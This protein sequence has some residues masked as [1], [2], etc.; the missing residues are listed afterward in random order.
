MDF[1]GLIQTGRERLRQWSLRRSPNGELPADATEANLLSQTSAKSVTIEGNHYVFG[2]DWR[3]YTDRKDLSQTLSA[4]RKSGL[5]HYA[6]NPTEDFVG[7]GRGID[8]SQGR[9]AYAGAIH[10]AESVSRGGVE[11]FV[12][13]LSDDLFSVTALNDSRP[14]ADFDMLG[15]RN[16]ILA[17]AGRYQFQQ[18]DEN[19]RQVGNTGLLENEEHVELSHAFSGPDG[20]VRVKALPDYRKLALVGL[21]VLIFALIVTLVWWWL[22]AEQRKADQAKRQRE[23]DPN[24]IYEKAIAS[25]FN[26]SGLPAQLQLEGWRQ[27]INDIPENH[28]GWALSKINCLPRQCEVLWERDYGNYKDFYM[29][30]LKDVE[31]SAEAQK[32]DNP[33][34]ATI[35]TV[36]KVPRPHPIP[37]ELKRIGLP[38]LQDT[39]QSLSSQLQDL[40]LLS[41]SAAKMKPPELYPASPG[42]NAGQLQKPV[43]RGEWTFTHELWSLGDLEFKGGALMFQNLL[44]RRDESS[45]QWMYTLTGNY[46][47][48]GKDF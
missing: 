43:L 23:Q 12:F 13:Q 47:A 10:L 36:L 35:Q 2:L 41:N 25:N 28:K 48:K 26:L 8:H 22:S 45:K 34:M 16:E 1:K 29:L 15:S 9:K 6:T 37:A 31:S 40:T 18:G 4:A 3:F 46:Y 20:S 42:L 32:E 24:Y 7:L 14:V 30:P 17:L 27:V 38:L 39:V 21:G 19:I 33:A 5:T 44:I 11:L